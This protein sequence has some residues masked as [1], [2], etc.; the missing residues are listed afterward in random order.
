MRPDP[1]EGMAECL[2]LRELVLVVGKDQVEAT[3]VDL[4]GLAETLLGHH[5]ALDMPTG[6]ALTPR[7]GPRGVLPGLGR[8]PQRE[9][10]G[11]LLQRVR[12]A[13]DHLVEPL[14]RQPAVGAEARDAEVD[15]A[16]G[17]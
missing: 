7:R 17:L 5:R 16:T 3:A 8:L 15:V 10:A 13:V 1:R 4:E 14:P 6:P 12:L 9:V 2:R 11:V